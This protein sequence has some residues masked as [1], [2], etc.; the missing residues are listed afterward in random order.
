[1][2]LDLFLNM[3]PYDVCSLVFTEPHTNQIEVCLLNQA[4]QDP[5]T[6]SHG[7]NANP[8]CVLNIV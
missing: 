1:M 4:A 3:C 2:E 7:L 8:V 6:L 5:S